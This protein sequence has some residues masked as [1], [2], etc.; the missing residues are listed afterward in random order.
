MPLG[1]TVV[2]GVFCARTISKGSMPA[3]INH[4]ERRAA[5]A[6][7]AADIIAQEG[8]DAA[9]VRRV[10]KEAGYSTKVVSHYFEDKRALLLMTYR[11]S[12]DESIRIA[13]A[14]QSAS[15]PD[16]RA[17]IAALLP[18]TPTMMRI[19]SVWFAFW[20][21]A[22]ADPEFAVEQSRQVQR[23][24]DQLGQL[25]ALDPRYRRLT[26]RAR[27][28]LARSVVTIL[29]GTALQATFDP[30]DWARGRQLAM[31]DAEFERATQ[32]VAG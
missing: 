2:S 8:L 19:W 5:L 29:I 16:A 10:A 1:R 18:T 17:A 30:R 28:E 7:I 26:K 25:L 22:T 11:Y 14:S 31:I 9:T 24:R 21:Y 13:I 20:S 15:F 6:R 3:L 23:A 4:D 12:A 27:T 32:R